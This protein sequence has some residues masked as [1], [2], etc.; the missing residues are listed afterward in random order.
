MRKDSARKSPQVKGKSAMPWATASSQYENHYAD[1]NLSVC[2]PHFQAEVPKEKS[3]YIARKNH[4]LLKSLVS[5]HALADRI[6]MPVFSTM[7]VHNM[8]DDMVDVVGQLCDK[9][10]RYVTS[11]SPASVRP[12]TAYTQVWPALQN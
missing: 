12:D 7:A 11:S 9:W 3:W 8:F 10:A 6:L 4:C 5:E 2:L 1:S